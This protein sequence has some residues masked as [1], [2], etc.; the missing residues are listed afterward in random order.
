MGL[1]PPAAHRS[2]RPSRDDRFRRRADPRHHGCRPRPGDQ[3]SSGVLRAHRRTTNRVRAAAHRP[4]RPRWARS[5]PEDDWSP[6]RGRHP[7]C[8][9]SALRRDRSSRDGRPLRCAAGGGSPRP[10]PGRRRRDRG[11]DAASLHATH[12]FE[13]QWR[14]RRRPHGSGGDQPAIIQDRGHRGAP[15]GTRDPGSS[16]M[17]LTAS[18]SAGMPTCAPTLRRVWGRMDSRPSV[19]AARGRGH[20]A[21]GVEVGRDILQ[22]GQGDALR[23]RAVRDARD[24]QRLVLRRAE[25]AGD[26]DD[27]D[28]ALADALDELPRDVGV[29]TPGTK[30]RSAPASR[31]ARPRS[32]ASAID[33]SSGRSPPARSASVRALSTNGTPSASPAAMIASTAAT[34]SSSG[35][36]RSSTLAP[37][38][39]TPIARAYGLAR[40]A[41]AGVEVGRDGQVAAARD[42]PDHVE[43]QVERDLLAVGIAEGRGDGVAGG[44]ERPRL[45]Q[46]GDRLGG[47]DVPHVDDA[48]DLGRGVQCA[49]VWA[50]SSW[51]LIRPRYPA[52]RERGRRPVPGPGLRS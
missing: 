2:G 21:V 32:I 3:S 33:S 41:V 18:P 25:R 22:R 29:D 49:R 24:A 37:T 8:R 51:V 19:Q 9:G 38:T 34:D 52:L 5:T 27:A 46:R 26:A 35:F 14:P 47:D 20:H 12:D 10:T 42:A 50:F 7:W 13:R 48:E 4:Q 28:L 30:T 43:H 23:H 40:V 45:G 15:G 39:P 6:G 1:P 17:P 36:S 44:R 11:R 31:Y 16:W